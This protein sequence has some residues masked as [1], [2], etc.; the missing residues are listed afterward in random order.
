MKKRVMPKKT[1]AE[2]FKE[3][4]INT[5]I[6]ASAMI[7]IFIVTFFIESLGDTWYR[8]ALLLGGLLLISFSFQKYLQENPKIRTI[9]MW[10][11]LA[12][13]V[14]GGILFLFFYTK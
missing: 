11:L 3:L 4:R 10:I 7:I 14:F 6:I 12:L 9:V 13:V 8:V 5:L 1:E 2:L